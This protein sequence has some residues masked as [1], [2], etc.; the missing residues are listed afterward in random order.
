MCII[1]VDKG[2]SLVY[3]SCM[4]DVFKYTH[5]SWSTNDGAFVQTLTTRTNTTTRTGRVQ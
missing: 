4:N 2:R 5:A 3:I 1:A